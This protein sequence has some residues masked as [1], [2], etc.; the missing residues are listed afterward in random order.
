MS[1]QEYNYEREKEQVFSDDDGRKL[2][3]KIRDQVSSQLLKS[4][5]VRMD[6]ATQLP[7]GV[8][9]ANNYE[10]WACVEF[11]KEIGEIVEVTDPE[12]VHVSF[13]IFARPLRD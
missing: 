12:K 1:F 11:L 3:L 5:V 6:Y 4:G 8:G 2:F 7:K 10:M 13:R 9:A